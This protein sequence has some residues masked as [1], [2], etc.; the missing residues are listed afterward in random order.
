MVNYAENADFL[1]AK[2]K[3]KY[4]SREEV[5]RRREEKN[6][7]RT[8]DDWEKLAREIIY[9]QLAL[10][11]RSE[12][13]LFQAL[14]R[15]DVP[16]DIA[17][18]TIVKFV[19]AGLVDDLRFAQMYVRTASSVKNVAARNLKYELKKRGINEE[20]AS[21]AVAEITAEDETR[22]AIKYAVKKI[23]TMTNLP[24]E[25]IYRRLYGQLARRGFSPTQ[26]KTALTH[27]FAQINEE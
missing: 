26:V 7:A 24:R 20:I 4:R 17:N 10:A 9:R 12:Y 15:R 21:Q 14:Q 1:N 22:A 19:E 23:T 3:S 13:Q 2:K 18:K 5:L 8:T 25:V 6:S 16:A 27:A 11:E